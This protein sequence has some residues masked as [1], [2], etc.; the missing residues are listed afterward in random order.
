M[1]MYVYT[2]TRHSSIDLRPIGDRIGHSHGNE[3][4]EDR[5]RSM[6]DRGAPGAPSTQHGQS[7]AYGKN[8]R[9]ACLF[10]CLFVFSLLYIVC[11]CCCVRLDVLKWS[12][13]GEV[14]ASADE[15]PTYHFARER[16]A[17]SAAS[18][19]VC[20]PLV[21]RRLLAQSDGVPH[22]RHPYDKTYSKR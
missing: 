9:A 3:T 13:E 22:C 19:Q 5:R 11:T 14:K 16:V 12:N 17:V 20:S 1:H 4:W 15:P 2:P 7:S 10:V 8:V 6:G 21:R 18:A